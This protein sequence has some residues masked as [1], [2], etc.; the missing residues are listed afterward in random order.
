M[1]RRAPSAKHHNRNCPPEPWQHSRDSVAEGRN[2][3]RQAV[4]CDSGA[5]RSLAVRGVPVRRRP[6]T[7]PKP[8][9]D[10]VRYSPILLA[11][12][13]AIVG[14]CTQQQKPAPPPTIKVVRE[15]V[16]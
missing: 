11:L 14:A 7:T 1:H 2:R 16:T 13:A 3:L 9:E 6:P 5:S 15:T 4:Q 12:A 10:L 8:D